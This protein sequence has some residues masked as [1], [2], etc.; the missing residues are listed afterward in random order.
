[1]KCFLSSA[2]IIVKHR[3]KSRSWVSTAGDPPRSF[4]PRRSASSFAAES[5]HVGN[6]VIAKEEVSDSATVL[7]VGR[8]NPLHRH[9]VLALSQPILQIGPDKSRDAFIRT[10][11][12]KQYQSTTGSFVQSSSILV[13]HRTDIRSK[14]QPPYSGATP[15]NSWPF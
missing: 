12:R 5:R 10:V 2:Y 13:D 6:T 9:K 14:L 1:M 11:E 7:R 15:I 3:D 8:T 4:S